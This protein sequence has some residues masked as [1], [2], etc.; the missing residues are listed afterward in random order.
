M[1]YNELTE[2]EKRVIL[3]KGTEPPFTGKYTYNWERGIYTCKRCGAKLYRST[4]KFDAGCGWPSFDDEIPGAIKKIPDPDGVRTEIV[5]ANCGAHLGHIFFGEGFTEK[6]V[7]H[8]VNSISLNFIPETQKNDFEKATFAAGCFWGVEYHFKKIKGVISTRVGYTGGHK[9][10]PTYEEVCTGKTGHAE[11][12][13]VIF[14]PKIISYEQLVKIFFE[15][16]D[17]TQINRQGPDVGEQYRSEIFYLDEEQKKIAERIVEQLKNKGY[18]IA[19]KITK[20]SVFWPAEEYHQDYYNKTG[21]VP[22]CHRYV[23]KF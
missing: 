11:A 3:Y 12:V 9:E 1:K 4:D 6:N 13:E 16:H 2:E 8:C 19:T 10:N 22:Y 14:N 20:A 23:K 7:R 18:K 17:P 5:C 21:G 15:I